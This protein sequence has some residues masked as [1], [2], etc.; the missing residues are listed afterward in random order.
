LTQQAKDVI[1][2]SLGFDYKGFSA[3]LSFNMRGNVLNNVG[4]RDEETSYTGNIY[5]WDFTIKQ[6]LPIEGLSLAL[7]GTNIFHNAIR[8][9]RNYRLNEQAPVTE[10]LVSVLYSPTI[11]QL[12]LRYSY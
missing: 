4:T 8:T 9:Y 3:R 10:N 2:A 5:R 1:N 7:N 11:F 12:N 6:Q